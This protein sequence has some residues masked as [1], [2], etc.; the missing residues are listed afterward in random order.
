MCSSYVLQWFILN[1]VWL[2]FIMEL[3]EMEFGI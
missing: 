3:D 2:M 1:Q